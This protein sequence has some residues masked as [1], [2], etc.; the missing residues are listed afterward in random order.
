MTC[1]KTTGKMVDVLKACEHLS[2]HGYDPTA[3]KLVVYT[4]FKINSLRVHIS[5][6]TR[7]ECL[8][9]YTTLNG[10]AWKVTDIGKAVIAGEKVLEWCDGR[11]FLLRGKDEP[12]K[13]AKV[14][15]AP[16]PM[17][18]VTTPLMVPVVVQQA[19]AP[20]VKVAGMVGVKEDSSLR[21]LTNFERM[22]GRREKHG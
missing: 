22:T 8:K 5:F 21:P 10:K 19:P 12:R 2:G 18:R 7:L 1:D 15:I 16:A 9:R 17:K 3:S 14:V 13:P 11:R 6:L 20:V 4:R